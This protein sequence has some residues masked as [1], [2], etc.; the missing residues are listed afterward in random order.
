MLM[1]LGSALIPAN[2]MFMF[3][4]QLIF[5]ILTAIVNLTIG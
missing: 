3:F 5:L 2:Q 1:T 4:V